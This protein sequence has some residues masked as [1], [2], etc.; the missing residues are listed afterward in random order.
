MY[1]EFTALYRYRLLVAL[2][3]LVSVV[4]TPFQLLFGVRN[5]GDQIVNFF[6]EYTVTMPG[7]GRV[8]Q[9]AAFDFRRVGDQ[10]VHADNHGWDA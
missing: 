1:G 3:E 8:C 4:M 5:S 9:F 7:V 2:N 6:H 10:K